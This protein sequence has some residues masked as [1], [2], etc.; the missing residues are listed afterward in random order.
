MADVSMLEVRA[1]R[2]A[3]RRRLGATIATLLLTC[4][5]LA[6]TADDANAADA[7]DANPTDTH[8]DRGLLYMELGEYA[9]ALHEFEQVM[10]IAYLSTDIREQAEVYADIAR[11]NK[12]GERLTLTSFV[13]AGAGYYRELSSAATQATGDNP[14]SDA[15]LPLRVNGGLHY[16]TESSYSIDGSLDYRFRNY[17]NSA[18]RDD[19]DLRWSG[20]VTRSL[21]RGSQSIG[22]RGRASYRGDPGYRHDYGLFIKR[23]MVLASDNRLTVELDVYRRDY[24]SEQNE[25]NYTNAGVSTTW[26]RAEADGRGSLGVTLN[27]GYEWAKNDRPDGDQTYYGLSVD[28]G[29]DIGK[30][31]SIFLFGWYEH[32]GFHRDRVIFDEPDARVGVDIRADDLY[33]FGGGLVHRIGDGWTLRPEVLYTR[34]ESTATFGNYSAIELWV[35][36]RRAF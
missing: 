25:R 20:S 9:R 6:S 30:S 35:A 1:R 29:R 23:G 15:F 10:Q 17:D 22:V 32:N 28:W 21:E 33:E 8:L 19:R 26:N 5:G 36:V 18:R 11:R 27:V 12:A 16:L 14:A 3:E 31:T 24:P 34:D 2:Q 4:G 13:A 7:T